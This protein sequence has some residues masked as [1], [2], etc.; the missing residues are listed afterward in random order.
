MIV[1]IVLIIV[2][3]IIS[4]TGIAYMESHRDKYLSRMH[5]IFNFAIF[6]L[7]G[8]IYF[9][10]FI[11]STGDYFIE[12]IALI[13]WKISII[14]KFIS[15]GLLNSIHLYLLIPNKSKILPFF[16]NS[17]LAGIITALLFIPGSIEIVKVE[18]L[19]GFVIQNTALLALTL[20]YDFF[21]ILILWYAQ[22]WSYSLI[23]DENLKMLLNLNLIAQSF[24]IVTHALFFLAQL[25]I[26]RYIHLVLYLVYALLIFLIILYK[27]EIF[28]VFTTVIENLVIFH[29]S[30][31]LLYSYNFEKGRELDDS[32]LKG[33][34]LIGINH[35]LSSFIKEKDKVS[36]IKMKNR[37]IVL[38]YNAE[39][40][41]ALLL[42]ANQ[43][44][45]FIEKAIKLFIEKFNHHNQENLK[46]IN[47]FSQLIDVS[48]FKN[49][50][51]ILNE[52]FGPY[53]NRSVK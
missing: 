13:I 44:N 10:L 24:T 47:N 51:S 49:A 16:L 31:I 9:I 28:I 19:Y 23:F 50:K 26:L 29:K 25:F 22:M 48:V 17:L 37:D 15:L 21:I 38:E 27:P 52:C 2:S 1:D 12:D 39:F 33:S 32:L 18:I 53:M 4:A 30:G 45:L 20:L 6:F 41:Y 42:I 46:K 5:R 7:F 8:I 43:K 36:I 35:I 34:I 3:L 11:L 40:G 14:V